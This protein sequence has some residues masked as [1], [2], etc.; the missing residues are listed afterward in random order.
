MKP[1]HIKKLLMSEVKKVAT[2]PHKYCMNG[3]LQKTFL[4]VPWIYSWYP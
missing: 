3:R 2:E 1:Q 4:T